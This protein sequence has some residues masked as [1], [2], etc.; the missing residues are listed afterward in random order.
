MVFMLFSMFFHVFFIVFPNSFGTQI[1]QIQTP[2]A[3]QTQTERSG[4]DALSD[5]AVQA[6]IMKVAKEK[7]PEVPRKQ[8]CHLSLD[9]SVAPKKKVLGG[10]F[11]KFF[12]FSS[13]LGE[14]DPIGWK[15]ST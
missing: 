15:K 4:K 1:Q 2:Q 5:P 7:F 10:G 9:G 12:W 14:I 3:L 11:K 13:L 6:E 8:G